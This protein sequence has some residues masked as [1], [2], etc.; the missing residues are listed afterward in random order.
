MGK[1]KLRRPERDADALHPAAVFR[2]AQQRH[3]TRGELHADLVGPP[4][5]QPDTEQAAT[6]KRFQQLIAQ[7]RFPDA[8]SLPGDDKGLVAP[9]VVE[10]QIAQLAGIRLRAAGT[11]RVIGLFKRAVRDGLAERGRRGLR[12][13]VDHH[14]AHIPVKPVDAKG[15]AAELRAQTGGHRALGI[16]SRRLHAH[17]DIRVA[18]QDRQQGTCFHSRSSAIQALGRRL[19]RSGRMRGTDRSGRSFPRRQ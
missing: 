11:D 2:V 14:A 18:V 13:R 12:A 3:G 4:G 5:E 7:N 9:G 10:Q 15:L 8:L 19:R 16:E 1:G 6:D 17:G